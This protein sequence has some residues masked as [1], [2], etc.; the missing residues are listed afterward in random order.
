M[1]NTPWVLADGPI[2]TSNRTIPKPFGSMRTTVPVKFCFSMVDIV[3]DFFLFV[4]T[5][6]PKWSLAIGI[7]VCRK[8][9]S[10]TTVAQV[11]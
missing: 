2:G 8:L 1:A 4:S 6:Y 5:G 10:P 7:V 9:H 3:M 11:G